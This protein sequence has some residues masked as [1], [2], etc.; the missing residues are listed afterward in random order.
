MKGWRVSYLLLLFGDLLSRI[1]VYKLQLNPKI[2]NGYK[3]KSKC[4]TY[5]FPA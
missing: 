3:H 2:I 5:A 4:F 1:E